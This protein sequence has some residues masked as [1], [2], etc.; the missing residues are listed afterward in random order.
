ML[1]FAV[2]LAA[3]LHWLRRH[4]GVGVAALAGALVVGNLFFMWDVRAGRLPSGQGITFGQ[5]M[6]TV[7]TRLGNPF[8]FPA[9]ALYAWRH[10]TSLV[11]YDELGRR[12]Y[13]YVSID[14]GEEDD[15][16]F[17]TS[18]WSERERDPGLSFRWAVTTESNLVVPLME[19]G[20]YLLEFRA[21][22]FRYEGAPQPRVTISVN[23]AAA[24]VSH[25][26]QTLDGPQVR[27]SAPRVAIAEVDVECTQAR[28]MPVPRAATLDLF[29]ELSKLLIGCLEC[30]TTWWI[31]HSLF[32][33]IA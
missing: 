22:P 1:V 9:N 10:G 19:R 31:G 20:S 27:R 2:G 7:Y 26:L 30:R 15:E 12:S 14:L 18:G 13:R 24:R 16:A 8:S 3:F 33:Q 23:G 11:Q 21:D 5:M 6:N 28:L 32:E 4:P 29:V 17:L 25:V